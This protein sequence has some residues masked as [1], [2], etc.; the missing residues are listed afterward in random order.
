MK[1]RRHL[2]RLLVALPL[3]VVVLTGC[4]FS[5]KH[6]DTKPVEPSNYL[7]QTTIPNVIANL[8]RSYTERN[9]EEYQKLLDSSYEYI[10]A[11]QDIGGP[12]NIPASW[13]RADELVSADHMF[14][15]ASNK[16]GY[17]AESISLSFTAGADTATVLNPSWRKVVL[18][19]VTLRV[20]SRHETT[21]DPLTYEVLGDQANLYFF[22]TDETAPGTNLKVWKIVRWEDKPIVGAVA[23]A[24]KI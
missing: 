12:N 7:P 9:Y 22:L 23:A 2:Y 10:F 5:P 1:H 8:S 18:K 19:D 13:G 11:P 14:N 20:Y 4:P 21:S 3:A 24:A 15:K 16:D 17:W 6:N